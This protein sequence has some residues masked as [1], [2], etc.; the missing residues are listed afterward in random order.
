MAD[1][2]AGEFA[3]QQGDLATAARYYLLAA[4]QS[5]DAG[6]AERATRIALVA[7]QDASASGAIARWRALAPDSVAMHA[8]AIRL[9]LDQGEHET[10]MDSARVLLA[11]PADAGFA[12]FLAALSEARGDEAVIARSVM[13]EV[14]AQSLLPAN[15]SAW[16][17]F[18]G[19]ARRLGDPGLAG[20]VLS[21]GQARF[22]DDPRVQLLEASRLRSEGQRVAARDK[23][24]ALQASGTL[25]PELVRGAA[26]EL[27]L[28]GEPAAAARMLAQG[29]QDDAS[30]G[31]R[32]S[33]LLAAGDIAG[34]QALYREIEGLDGVPPPGRR[35]LLG[36]VAEALER[37]SD[38][39]RWYAGV[40]RGEGHDLAQ[41]RLALSRE[42]LGRLGQALDTLHELQADLSADG[43]RVRDSYLLEA[44]LVARGPEPAAAL[45]VIERGLAV[46]EGDPALLYARAMARERADEVDA[47]LADLRQI[48]DDN[49][50]DARALNAYAYTLA[51]RRAAYEEALPFVKRAHA[52]APDSAAVLDSLGWIELKLG[53]Q[54]RALEL[55]T[56]AWSLMKDPEIAAHLGEALWAQGRRDEARQV[57]R[58][59]EA[60]DPDNPSLRRALEAA[61]P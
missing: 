18:S 52:L 21:A 30:Q 48:I 57:W 27:A 37:W 11:L 32:A 25:P 44:E 50:R 29:P 16:L 2:M 5:D 42:R 3:L 33:W 40:P 28:L 35:L 23:L 34:L 55:L 10:A 51:E 59:G 26:N 20:R 53:R 36:H 43:E 47:A 39:E 6:L 14:F 22:P 19:L 46:F 15:L 7:G 8:A 17:R 49:P 38:A 41:L 12:P 54:A 61:K 13:G 1:V 45:P 58:E 24:L 9:A 56:Q 60:L 31:Q 4:Q